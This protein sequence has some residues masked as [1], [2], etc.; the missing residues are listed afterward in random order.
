MITSF[1]QLDLNKT[2]SYAD[3]L[4]WQFSER[5]ELFRGRVF[6]MSPAPNRRH[7]EI[8]FELS[9]YI[10]V[11]LKGKHC[12]AFT[13]PFDVRLP[14]PENKQK[15]GK[16]DTVVQPD[17][18]VVCDPSKLDEQGCNGAPDFIIEILSPGNSRRE[19]KTKF[20]LYETAGVKEY[21]L[22]E[23][24]R[25]CVTC[26]HLDATG[27]YVGS[28]PYF[29]DDDIPSWVLDGFVLKGRDILNEWEDLN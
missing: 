23:P 10:G 27:Q 28:R 29:A 4:T 2:Y 11:F 20:E 13:A 6:R 16:V 26:Y 24:L 25:E 14:L 3:Y 19:M 18:V 5:V 12:K 17:I 21:W 8:S 7:Q 9:V 1:D 15:S 22:V